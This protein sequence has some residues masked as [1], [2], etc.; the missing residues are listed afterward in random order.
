M[1]IARR[2]RKTI[3]VMLL[4]ATVINYIDRSALSIAM[5]FISK[6]F[7]LSAS[8]KGLVFSAFS[9]G[10][11]LFNFL[12]GYFADR[13]G[14]RRVLTISMAG[15]SV[16]CGL[17]A[18]ISGFWS[19]LLIRVAFGMG[20]GPNASTANKVVNNWFPVREHATA[21]GIG[22]AG[23]PLGGALAGPVIGML[24]LSFGWRASFMVM[25]VLGL[26]WAVVWRFMAT[27]KPDQHPRVS[28]AELLEIEGGR[29]KVDVPVGHSPTIATVVK[30]RAVVMTGISLFAFNYIL[31][32]FITWFPTYLVEAK[33]INLRDMSL[34][35][36]LPWV[37]GT[38]GF[39]GGGFL[40]DYILRRTGRRMFS[41]K[42][43]AVTSMFV[44][45]ICVG[46]AGLL[47]DVAAVLF[48][49]TIAIG[50]LMM[51]SPAYW[52]IMQDTVP[53]HQVGTA[54]GFIHAL[55]NCS[56]I[57]GPAVTGLLI[58]RTGSYMSAF[59]LS[60]AIGIIGALLLACF[61][62]ERDT[63]LDASVAQ[64]S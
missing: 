41:R 36:S 16:A 59:V 54:S 1:K 26:T 56:G 17:T 64:L 13:F 40:A 12:G 35:S 15:W 57:V 23:G 38:I 61:V 32:F 2:Y 22:Q 19:M 42:I 37:L 29:E 3:L 43:V 6:D 53:R 31:F 4:L 14:A 20:E 47:D 46:L 51:A 25:A 58:E 7:H 11:A 8:E 34:F 39:L 60:G 55:S 48:V 21:A 30:N 49:M 45:A 27:E 62:K 5:P 18:A 50:L 9:V 24:A 63:V 28:K 52:A 33:H 44:A 10:Y